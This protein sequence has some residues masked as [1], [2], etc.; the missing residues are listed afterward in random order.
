MSIQNSFQRTD[1]FHLQAKTCFGTDVDNI[2][3]YFHSLT[4]EYIKDFRIY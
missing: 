1:A 4:L 2:R 3:F